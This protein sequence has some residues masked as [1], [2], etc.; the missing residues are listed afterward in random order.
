MFSNDQLTVGIVSAA[1]PNTRS[2]QGNVLKQLLEAAS[3]RKYC[4]FS[5]ALF[6]GQADIRVDLS[7]VFI[8]LAAPI[9][10]NRFKEM[11]ARFFRSGS[12]AVLEKEVIRR[13]DIL[14]EGIR[15]HH[16]DV[17]VPCT[18]SL[19]DIP[20]A[21]LA[22]QQTG[23]RFFPYIFDDYVLQWRLLWQ[24]QFA[25]KWEKRLMPYASGV[26]CPNEVLVEDYFQR[27]GIK[28]VIIRNP[29]SFTPV[30]PA[31]RK[32]PAPGS[33][34][35]IVYTGSV[36]DV[37]IDCFERLLEGGEI[38]AVDIE[39]HIYSPQ[40][41]NVA[42]RI[43]SHGNVIWHGFVSQEQAIQ[44]QKDADLLYLP[45]SFSKSLTEIVRSAAPGKTGELLA[46]G[47]PILAHVPKD[48]FLCK[49]LTDNNAAYVV[50][51]EE[52][53]RISSV[54]LS[55]L[56]EDGEMNDIIKNAYSISLQFALEKSAFELSNA[57]RLDEQ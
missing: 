23:I 17:L 37:Q 14:V 49:F 27:H 45:L 57:L 44:A 51:S 12:D 22:A 29:I 32:L 48:S 54:L 21:F 35:R 16:I 42:P 28:P 10:R 46:S 8:S 55:V 1:L 34:L 40:P 15:T 26:F 11:F 13:K 41:P 31:L 36:Y 30:S 5:D 38:A 33:P 50:D 20:A 53:S 19:T 18:A 6:S 24:R 25:L 39:L 43:A 56:S 4:F 52:P 47:T 2:G 7:G 9:R 3:F